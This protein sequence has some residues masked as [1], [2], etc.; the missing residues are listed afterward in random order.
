MIQ[1]NSQNVLFFL[2]K[3][4]INLYNWFILEDNFRWKSAGQRPPASSFIRGT[5]GGDKS[6]P[7]LYFFFTKSTCLCGL[8]AIYFLCINLFNWIFHKYTI[9]SSQIFTKKRFVFL[10]WS[11]IVHDSSLRNRPFSFIFTRHKEGSGPLP[12]DMSPTHGER[13]WKLEGSQ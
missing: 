11:K 12:R 1:D 6:V 3:T 5:S 13:T 2:T 10:I 8:I 4:R 7:Q 9:K